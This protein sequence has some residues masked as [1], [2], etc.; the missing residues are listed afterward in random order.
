MIMNRVFTQEELEEMG[1]RTGD[2]LIEA[3]EVGDKERAKKLVR[4]MYREFSSMHDL[5]VDWMAGFMD[6]ICTNYGEDALYQALR[7]VA[8]VSMGS[9]VEATKVDFRRQVQG[10]AFRMRGHLQP[11]KVEEDDEKVCVTMEPCG[12]GQRL[13]QRGAYGPPHNLTRIQK[14]RAETWSMSDFPVY[15]THCPILEILSIEQLGYLVNVIFPSQKVAEGP[16]RFCIYK[17]VEDIPEEVYTRVGKKKPKV[18]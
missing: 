8:D 14:P 15:C 16:C 17:N 11:M 2:L 13:V 18:G 7:K 4:R 9:I 3:I 6:Y 10:L 1:K 5:Y 12:S